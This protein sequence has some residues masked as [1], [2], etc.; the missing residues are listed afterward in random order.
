L[1]HLQRRSASGVVLNASTGAITGTPTA[2][3]TTSF[4]VKVTD[5]TQPT[6]ETAAANLSITI[7]A[8]LTITT[9]SVPN[10]SV[11]AQY[12]A[13]VNAAGGLQPYS[14]SIISGSLPPGLNL[15]NNNTLTISGQ[16][17]ATGTYNFT[18]Q[19]TDNE[20]TPASASNS[21]T[22]VI[23]TQPPGYT[24]SGTITYGGSKTAGP[25]CS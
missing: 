23:G 2:T 17:T 11:G 21:Y 5:S 8:A 7:N 3:G 20:N 16:P 19:V 22:I 12:N 25:I 4:T 6:H 14:W 24:V 15:N 10:G 9:T 13:T 18:L 1:E